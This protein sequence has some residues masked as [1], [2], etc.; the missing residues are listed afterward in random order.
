M[1]SKKQKKVNAK[2]A[3]RE[4]RAAMDEAKRAKDREK[5]AV[6]MRASRSLLT[7]SEIQAVQA[8]NT[9]KHVANYAALAPEDRESVKEKRAENKRVTENHIKME[10]VE[11][12]QHSV[13]F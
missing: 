4:R 3:Q 8:V 12:I 1:V 7:E 6:N 9:K 2:L 13:K 10:Q 11:I 5:N